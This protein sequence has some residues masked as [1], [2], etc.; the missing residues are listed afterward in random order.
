MRKR[1]TTQA[2]T[3]IAVSSQQQLVATDHVP[4]AMENIR[5][6]SAQMLP[7][8]TNKQRRALITCTSWDRNSTGSCTGIKYRPQRDQ[9]KEMA[10]R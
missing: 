10:H 3:Q 2:A 6:G 1:R 7:A 4:L 8:G 5:Q 9:R